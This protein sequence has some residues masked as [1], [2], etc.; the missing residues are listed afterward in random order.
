MTKQDKIKHTQ[1]CIAADWACAEDSFTKSENIIFET[2][3]SFFEIATFGY[4]AVIRADKHIVD[5]CINNFAKTPAEEIMDGENLYLIEAKM[6]EH[7]KQLAGEHINFLHLH[8]EITVPKPT[9]FTFELYE[10]PRITELYADNRFENALGSDA[11]GAELAIVA[12]KENDIAAIAAVDSHHHGLWQMGIDT[13]AAHRG[14]G[15][16][17]Y[18]VKEMAI[19]SERRNQVPFYATW[20]AN[21]ASMR[22]ALGAGFRPVWTRYYAEEAPQ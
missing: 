1:A 3:K 18:L 15:L 14:Q 16:A 21:I 12:K 8:P 4:N 20:S 9:G 17:A 22:V 7:G 6:R 11:T 10:K 2:N 13:L 19:E 5:W